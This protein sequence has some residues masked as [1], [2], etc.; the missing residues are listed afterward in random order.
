VFD[1]V[2]IDPPFISQSV[3]RNYATTAS[4]LSKGDKARVIATTV[5]ENA[6]LMESLFGCRRVSFR[7]VIP[8]LV[9]QYSAFANFPTSALDNENS[10]LRG[11]ESS[12]VPVK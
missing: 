3:W 8:H 2:V 12:T 1:L 4:L 7:P 6:A 9:Y 11:E 5:S 10:E